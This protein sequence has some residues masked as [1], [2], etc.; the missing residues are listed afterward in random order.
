MIPFSLPFILLQTF[1]S[2]PS[3]AF[4]LDLLSLNTLTPLH[5][6]SHRYPFHCLYPC[7]MPTPRLHIPVLVSV[8]IFHA[9]CVLSSSCADYQTIKN[10]TEISCRHQAQPSSTSIRIHQKKVK[11]GEKRV[12]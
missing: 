6:L 11:K 4:T 7:F 9:R 3:S 10:V 2:S 12:N 8:M 5:L 1:S